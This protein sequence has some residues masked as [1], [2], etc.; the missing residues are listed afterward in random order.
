M[1]KR[2]VVFDLDETLIDSKHRVPNNPD[3]TLNLTR[4]FELKTY[5]SVMRDS[6]LPL[7]QIFKALNREENYIVICTARVMAT[8]DRDFMQKYGLIA[9]KIL[10]RPQDGSENHIKDNILKRRKLQQLKNL[11][12]FREKDWFMF[13]DASPIIRE[14]REIGI[15]CLNA[16]KV[17]KRLEKT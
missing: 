12:Q 6:L 1:I 5:D 4:Y 15:V 17:N 16:I 13:D 2:V 8:A 14:M 7:V 11:R 9:H 10:C 3:G